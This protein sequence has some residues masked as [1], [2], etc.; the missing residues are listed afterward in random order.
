MFRV[1][2]ILIVPLFLYAE[3][4]KDMV[5]REVEVKKVDKIFASSPTILYSLYAVD[6]SK[7]A[8]L[9]FPFNDQEKKYLSKEVASLPVIGGWF[10]K[11]RTPNSE[12]VLKVKPD[13]I[14][15][16]E[17]IQIQGDKKIKDALGGVDIPVFYLDSSTLETTIA[18]FL[19]LGELTSNQKRAREL[20]AYG[21]S[22]LNEAKAVVA[23]ATKKPRVYY[24][25]E[26]NGLATEC[27]TSSHAE[28]IELA[29]GYNV[30][31]CVARDGF[32]RE[33]INFEQVLAYNPEIILVYDPEFFAKIYKDPNWKNIDAVK[34]KRVYLLPKGPFS[35][36]DRPPSFM[37]IIGLQWLLTVFHDDQYKIDLA[38]EAKE[39]YKL[40]LQVELTDADLKAILGE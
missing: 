24:A 20:N 29:G 33:S 28:L 12:M 30:H 5:G 2:L 34:N 37:K 9:N 19:Y 38:S 23:K 40:F 32:G 10:G 4:Y 39:F 13:L 16:G 14:L 36:F 25:Q 3:I 22:V 35:W 1:L 18:S 21:N 7:I 27:H 6:R 11:G 8:G 31:R 15:L 17:H 26:K